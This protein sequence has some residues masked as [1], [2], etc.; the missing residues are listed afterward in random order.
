M[1]QYQ[2]VKGYQALCRFASGV[3][4]PARAAFDTF[5]LKKKL[6]PVYMARVE[7]EKS[8]IAEC[9]GTIGENGTP[10]FP[11]RAEAQAY[12]DSMIE[13]SGLEV[14]ETFE[15]IKISCTLLGDQMILP[16]DIEDLNGFIT[17][18]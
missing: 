7:T 1:T 4:L 8:I 14:K 15:P 18:E 5:M 6:E 3:S 12:R 13:L 10:A 16:S 11:G 17:F 2:F 9:G